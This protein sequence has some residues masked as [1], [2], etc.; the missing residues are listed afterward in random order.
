MI[1]MLMS[2]GFPMQNV[3]AKAVPDT[4]VAAAASAPPVAP[5]AIDFELSRILEDDDS[6][7]PEALNFD[8]QM[9]DMSKVR[10]QQ[11]AKHRACYDLC[12]CLQHCSLLFRGE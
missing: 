1:A 8:L 10:Y 2:C 9:P 11:V 3:I 6:E 4:T 5:P 7:L 12:L